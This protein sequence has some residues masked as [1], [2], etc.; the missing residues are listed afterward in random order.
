[1]SELGTLSG[2]SF[3]Y[4]TTVGRVTGNPHTI[5]IWFALQRNRLYMLA[6][7][8]FKADWV[9]NLQRQPQ[10]KVRIGERTFEGSATVVDEASEDALARTL[11]LFKY[12]F[13][14][15]GDLTSWGR[16]A[17]PVAVDLDLTDTASNR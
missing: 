8:R 14:Y 15:S 6:G 2:E 3:C 4:L 10:V 1:M 7:G 17:L 16:D 11:L 5:E 12:R 13:R 9:R